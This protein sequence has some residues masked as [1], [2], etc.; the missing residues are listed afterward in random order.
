MSSVADRAMREGKERSGA[1]LADI[2]MGEGYH[3]E[4]KYQCGN[5]EQVAD[6]FLSG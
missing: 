6:T 1:S 5:E 4:R 2:A 3:E